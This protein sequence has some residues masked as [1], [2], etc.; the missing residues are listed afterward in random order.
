MNPF[1]DRDERENLLTPDVLE[2]CGQRV[3][4]T[5]DGVDNLFINPYV[6]EAAA[7]EVTER[8][9]TS[10]GTKSSEVDSSETTAET[11]VGSAA[12]EPALAADGQD[13]I[14]REIAEIYAAQ[15]A[16]YRDSKTP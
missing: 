5:D 14:R 3:E 7:L 13:E 10:D 2:S 4:A 15:E 1:I 12:V 6:Q 16:L 9:Q 8:A 11:R